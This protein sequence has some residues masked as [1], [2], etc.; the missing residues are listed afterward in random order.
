MGRVGSVLYGGSGKF[1]RGVKMV[2]SRQENRAEGIVPEALQ[3][4]WI[5]IE[6]SPPTH[7]KPR[8]WGAGTLQMTRGSL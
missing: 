7:S 3:K 4:D 8:A 5:S 1:F 6:N 2:Q